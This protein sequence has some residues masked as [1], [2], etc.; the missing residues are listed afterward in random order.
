MF[1]YNDVRSEND[2]LRSEVDRLRSADIRAAARQDALDRLLAATGVTYVDDVEQITASVLRDSVGNFDDDMVSIDV[3][4]RDGVAPGMA[5]VTAAGLVRKGRDC[6]HRAEHRH[7]DQQSKPG[8]RRAP[9]R[10][11]RCGARSRDR[12]RADQVRGGHRTALARDRGPL[13]AAGHREPGGHRGR[14]PLSREH[15]GGVGGVRR[16]GRGGAGAAGHGRPRRGR[17][18]HWLCHRGAANSPSTRHRSARTR[19]SFRSRHDR[20][21]AGCRRGAP[22]PPVSPREHLCGRSEA[23]RRVFGGSAAAADD[24]RGRAGARAWLPNC[25]PW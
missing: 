23:D 17:A 8:D 10:H 6:R 5:V 18:R 16:A 9:A 21:T 12:R 20:A 24:L 7:H 4:H 13:G 19:R 3:G 22:A 15:T 14:E 11:R 2:R 25:R 1:S